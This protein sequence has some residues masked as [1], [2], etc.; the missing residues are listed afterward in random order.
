MGH[1]KKIHTLPTS[2]A[3]DRDSAWARSKILR[4]PVHRVHDTRRVPPLEFDS[5]QNHEIRERMEQ[6]APDAASGR[7]PMRARARRSPS[8]HHHIMTWKG[9]NR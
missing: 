6:R 1:D 4:R 2:E 7:E 8:S 9:R 3:S 5:A